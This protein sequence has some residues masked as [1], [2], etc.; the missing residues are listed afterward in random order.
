MSRYLFL[1]LLLPSL[2]V[3]QLDTLWTRHINLGDGDIAPRSIVENDEGN[4]LLAGQGGTGL[5]NVQIRC[6]LISSNGNPSWVQNY[7]LP[8]WPGDAEPCGFAVMALPGDEGNFTLIANYLEYTP[9]SEWTGIFHSYGYLMHCDPDGNVLQADTIPGLGQA[10]FWCANRTADGGAIVVGQTSATWGNQSYDHLLFLKLSEDGAIEWWNSA[11]YDGNCIPVRVEQTPDGGY[12]MA[13]RWGPSGLY[14]V[15]RLSHAIYCVRADAVGQILWGHVFTGVT[16]DGMVGLAQRPDGTFRT[17][18]TMR[19]VGTGWYPRVFEVGANGDSLDEHIY[20]TGPDDENYC[21]DLR[22]LED[23]T[24]AFFTTLDHG[25][26]NSDV[27]ILRL[28]ED[29]TVQDTLIFGG[30]GTD[31]LYGSVPVHSG[32]FLSYGYSTSGC[33]SC[34]AVYL[35]RFVEE[36][37]SS[38]PHSDLIPYPSSL[39]LS[40]APNPFNAVTA[41]S[42]SVPNAGAVK[43]T[44][45]DVTGRQVVTL[46]D[47]SVPAGDYRTPFDGSSL[48]TGIYFARLQAGSTVRT[49]KLVLLK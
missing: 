29:F 49:Q 21:W 6:M 41:L 19:R 36:S 18:F 11:P 24:T 10:I 7:V 28:A 31:V 12:V 8:Q 20:S 33:E 22:P 39:S 9:T 35:A 32:G 37:P 14:D 1:L 44:V 16:G 48:A 17:S 43:L 47:K 4:F 3:A 15:Y 40:S 2:A 27:R 42:F 45:F 25:N 46:F 13:G 5:F 30:N 34:Q 23:G 26:G 38:S